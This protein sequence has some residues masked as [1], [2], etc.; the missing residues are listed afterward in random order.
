MDNKFKFR[1]TCYY[2]LI[3]LLL[4]CTPKIDDNICDVGIND[5]TA[6]NPI[7]FPH[8]ITTLVIHCTATPEGRDL[9]RED[10][11]RIWESRDYSRPGYHIVINLKGEVIFQGE[12]DDCLMDYDEMRWGVADRNHEFLHMSYVGG[13]DSDFNP[14][15][16]RT[17]AQVTT[18]TQMITFIKGI[19]PDIQVKGHKDFSNKACPSFEVSTLLPTL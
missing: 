14:K 2:L 5:P 16:T 7:F 18:L 8:N 12:I 11:N 1:Y 6:Y 19:C 3:A 9:T 4:A 13:V 10:L 15:D 17:T